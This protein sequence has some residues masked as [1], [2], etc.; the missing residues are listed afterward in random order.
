MRL[1][2][3]LPARPDA[4][5]FKFGAIFNA[6]A[7]PAP[8]SRFGHYNL[9]I[10]WQEFANDQYS[11]CVFAGAA[12]EHM[13]WLNECG[14]AVSFTDQAVLSDYTAVT[15]FD[16]A[17]PAT[18]QGTDMSAA[19]SYRRKTG[20]ADAS[21]ARHKVDSYVALRP[22]DFDQL[23][24]ATYLTG[25]CGVGI[26]VPATADAQF[27]AQS[28]WDAAADSEIV[29][30]HYI[31]CIGRNSAGN[32][33]CVTWGRLHA[34]TPKFYETFCDEAICYIDLEAMGAKGL[35]PEGYNATQLQQDLAALTA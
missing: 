27:D 31:P 16:P 3:K 15:G 4:V 6:A 1:Y 8:P 12:H 18:D 9:P 28:P 20:I 5:R 24:L 13:V 23:M 21:G 17:K 30:G 34:M 32:L 11:D 19:A 2:G 7:L 14:K 26:R 22:G 10:A 25:A 33:L 35:T 29:G